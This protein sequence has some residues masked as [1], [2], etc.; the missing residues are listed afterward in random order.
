MN[1][2]LA[3]L[4]TAMRR[5]QEIVVSYRQ[6]LAVDPVCPGIA[7][8]EIERRLE[9]PLPFEGQ[10]IA[11]VLAAVEDLVV[12]GCTKV[13]HPRFLAWMN[14][15]SCDAGIVGEMINVGLAQVPFTFKG[16]PSATAIE[17]LVGR[18]FCRLFGLPEGSAASFT[19]GG[20]LA[21]LTALAVARESRF[22][23]SGSEGVPAGAGA[24]KL[25]VSEQGHVSIDRSVGLLGLG[26]RNLVKIG[27]DARHRMELASLASAIRR[28]EASGSRP[29]CV[30]AQAGSASLGAVDEIDALADLC[31]R[32][33]LWLHVDAAYG[34]AAVL[35]ERGRRVLKGIERADSITTD[36]HKWFY[37][38]V[39]T[40]LA[41]FRNRERLLETFLGSSCPSYRGPMD[42]INLMNNGL[43]IAQAPKA[44]K[45]WFALKAYGLKAL[46]ACI[47]KD[48][49]LARQFAEAI[50][51]IPG[52]EVLGEVQ[53]STVCVRF[54]G[55]DQTQHR[56]LER[57]ESSG[58]ALLSSTLVGGRTAIRVCFANHRTQMDDVRILV[59]ALA[60]A[61]RE[62]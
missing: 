40:G 30:V 60:Q 19:G 59:D 5:A 37:M 2:D 41:L 32:H 62:C 44:F 8:D 18:W 61:G 22:P 11:K 12:P 26:T 47:D 45:V 39:E 14:N 49:D 48:L 10:G 1:L 31:A 9:E 6:S 46:Q 50:A 23:G 56:I 51:A 27:T 36:P 24:P 54:R 38:P 3:D 52:W 58:L 57:L 17:R 33:G 21:N 53:L 43:Q 35:T 13:G 28:D 25:Y 34:G 20:T 29:F 55:T 16:G 7:Y 4:E 42:E 15:S